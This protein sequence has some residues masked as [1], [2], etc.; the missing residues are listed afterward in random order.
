MSKKSLS[1]KE[2]INRINEIVEVIERGELDIDELTV[3]VKEATDLVA[4]CKDKLQNAEIDL[5]TSLDKLN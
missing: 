5:Q 3:L 1:Y 4:G 2:S